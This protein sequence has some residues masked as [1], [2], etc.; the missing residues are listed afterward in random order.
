MYVLYSVRYAKYVRLLQMGMF[1]V[2]GNFCE[3]GRLV[4]IHFY[5]KAMKLINEVEILQFYIHSTVTY[6]CLIF[7]HPIPLVMLPLYEATGPK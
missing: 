2:L 6:S 5:I 7:T 3:G 1:P 4:I